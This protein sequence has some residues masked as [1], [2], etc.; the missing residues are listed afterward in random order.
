MNLDLA[1]VSDDLNPRN[2]Y[3][4]QKKGGNRKRTDR[5]QQ[6]IDGP[7]DALTAA[8]TSTLGE[9]L[10]IVGPHSRRD[11]GDVITPAG[12]NISPDL[13]RAGDGTLLPIDTR[14]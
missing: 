8:A 10:L 2:D 5:N 6:N 13:I 9:M 12:Q 4:R 3:H 14:L 1:D 11:T 7:C